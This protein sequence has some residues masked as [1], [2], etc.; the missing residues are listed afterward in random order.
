MCL[1]QD[2]FYT[3]MPPNLQHGTFRAEILLLNEGR[4]RYFLKITAIEG[5]IIDD[6]SP[7]RHQPLF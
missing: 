5:L 1:A 3:Q 6:G 2:F 4:N 7:T